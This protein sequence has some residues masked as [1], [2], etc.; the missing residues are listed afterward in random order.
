M[1]LRR[2]D[3]FSQTPLGGG[4]RTPRAGIEDDVVAHD[5]GMQASVPDPLSLLFVNCLWCFMSL[6]YIYIYIYTY[7]HILSYIIICV[8]VVVYVCQFM[9]LLI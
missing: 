8:F 2:G 7:I 6:L 9:C 1:T 5:G 4:L 3:V